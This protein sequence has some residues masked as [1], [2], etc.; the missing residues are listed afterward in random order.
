MGENSKIQVL[1]VDD[2]I[3]TVDV[4]QNTVDW[5]KLGVT[6][7]YTAY[8][9]SFAKK[10][11]LEQEIDIVISDIEMPQGTGIDLLE[12]FREQKLPGEFLLLTCHE[13][14]DYATNAIKYQAC[15]YLLKP[16]NVNVM[17]VALK[18]IILKLKEEQ[19]LQENSEYGKWVKNNQRQLEVSFWSRLLSGHIAGDEDRI[20]SEIKKRKLMLETDV[21]YCL[22]ISK[23]TG[24]EKD[25]EKMS[26]DLMLFVIENIHSEIFCGNPD[27]HSVVCRDYDDYYLVA[28][29]CQKKVERELDS[30]CEALRRDFKKMFSAEITVCIG[31]DC[32]ISEMYETFH[33]VQGLIER[34]VAY[35][36]SYFHEEESSK[37]KEI[38]QSVFEFDKLEQYLADKKKME[39]LSYLKTEL[40]DK[41]FDKTLSDRVLQRGKEEIL[42]A[43]YMYLGK[44]GIQASGLLID[45]NLEQ[46]EKKAAQSVIDMIRWTNYLIECTFQY[47]KSVQKGYSLS[48]KVDQYIREHYKESIGRTEIAEQF[49]LAPEYLSKTYKKQMGKSIKDTIAECRIEEA[50]RMLERGERVSD[51][52]EAVGFDN[53]TYF[54]TMFKKYTGIS[55]NQY[56]KK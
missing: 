6:D 56:R 15:E 3:A 37:E 52:A 16:F 45:E 21:P 32:R 8:N 42:Q 27:N 35:Y 44:K 12:W 53:F 11:L 40:N 4:I 31:K 34:N 54:S 38:A 5:N 30:S 10:I 47:E 49:Y 33:R 7:V 36:G 17:D 55:P 43:V 24:I 51:V 48:E 28:V 26:P 9:I 50:K 18:K 2:D 23:I 41:V 14:F 13:S 46:L 22:V 1:I 25:R 39:I 29:I 20:A 19:K